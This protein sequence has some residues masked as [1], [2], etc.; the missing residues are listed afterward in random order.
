MKGF[1]LGMSMNSNTSNSFGGGQRPNV[2]PGC[3]KKIGGAATQKL[4]EWF[5][6]SCFVA[7]ASYTFGNES[8]LDNSLEAPG[9][10]NWDM[11]V[12]KKFAIDKDGRVNLQFRAEFFNLFNRVQFGV[13]NTSVG[14]TNYGQTSSQQNLPRIA[15]FALRMN[16]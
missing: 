14:N 5:N 8:R 7:P 3:S 9:V 1:P 16:F 12:V 11:S 4:G 6:T 2:V 10:A 13:P 15:Q